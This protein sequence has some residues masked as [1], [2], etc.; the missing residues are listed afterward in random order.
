MFL[1][2]D[3]NVGIGTTTPGSYKLYVN[4]SSYFN[5]AICG[6]AGAGGGRIKDRGN[7]NAVSFNWNGA[8][9]QFYVEEVLVKTFV[10]DHPL[11]HDKY[12][13]HGTLEGPEA[14]VY[15]RGTARLEN[16]NAEISLPDYFEALTREDGRTIILSNID[17]F[18]RLMVKKVNGKK[19]VNNRFTVVAEDQKS[20]QEFDWE[21][22]AVRK[23]V[24]PLQAEQCKKG[25]E[26]RG[27]G[28]YTYTV[29]K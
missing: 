18:D 20:C 12:L 26:V 22:K 2:H 3:G 11:D 7:D 4:G 17:G 23:D 28:P 1:D 16:G 19:I 13:I 6:E 10:I 15:Y 9:L 21:V 29:K 8:N 14:G 27:N 25:L 5:G 24:K